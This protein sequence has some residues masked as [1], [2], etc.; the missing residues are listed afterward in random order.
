MPDHRYKVIFWFEELFFFE[1]LYKISKNEKKKLK[2]SYIFY[3]L[4]GEV[5]TGSAFRAIF[6]HYLSQCCPLIF[7]IWTTTRNV[8]LNVKCV[9]HK[10]CCELKNHWCETLWITAGALWRKKKHTWKKEFDRK[11]TLLRG[12]ERSAV[13][14]VLNSDTQC[15]RELLFFCSVAAVAVIPLA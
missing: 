12:L 14:I 2:K 7:G 3:Q 1:I 15:K 9:T 10:T 11:K 6:L 8:P 5:R 13:S 4:L